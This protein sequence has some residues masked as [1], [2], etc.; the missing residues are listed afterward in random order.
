MQS[1]G[2]RGKLA[3]ACQLKELPP[4]MSEAPSAAASVAEFPD[5]PGAD[6]SEG[7]ELLPP[8]PRLVQFNELA[9]M[10]AFRFW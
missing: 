10:E 7:I 6:G 4:P 5:A 1:S 3:F 8:L 9:G 2:A